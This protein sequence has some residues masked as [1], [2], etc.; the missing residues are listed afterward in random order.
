MKFV[1]GMMIH[2]GNPVKSYVDTA[3]R[4]VLLRQGVIGVKVK[5]LKP[6]DETG[7]NGPKE[8]YPDIVT[9][10]EPKGEVAPAVQRSRKP[11]SKLVLSP[12]TFWRLLNTCIYNLL[13]NRNNG[14]ALDSA[15]FNN[16]KKKSSCSL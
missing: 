14:G 4:H 3:V 12:D 2:S 8:Q 9:I 10:L 11:N 15:E 13:V 7:M 16:L 5:I 6:R 1:D